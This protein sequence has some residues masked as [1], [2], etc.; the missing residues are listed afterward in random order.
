MQRTLRSSSLVP[1]GLVVDDVV[2]DGDRTSITVRGSKSFAV[3]PACGAIS[4]RVH[5]RYRRRVGDLPISGK[6]VELQVL[7]RRFRCDAVLC[8]R[9]IF[10]ERFDDGALAPWARRTARLDFVVHHLGLALGGRPAASFARRLMLPVSNDTLLRVVRRRPLL[11]RA[12]SASTTGLGGAISGTE[13]SSAT[14]SG[15]DRSLSCP[16]ESR[17][18]RR[19]GSRG[20]RKLPCSRVTAAAVTPLQRPRH[21]RTLPRSP[22]V[23]ISWRT[24]ATPSSMR[25]A[26]RCARCEPQS[27]PPPLIP[28]CSPS[29]SASSMRA[30]YAV[31]TPTRQSSNRLRRA[32]P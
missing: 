25:F 26:N 9:F 5:S 19:P 11:R 29:P 21:F 2:C 27:A 30:I 1:P 31:R 32:S 16:T 4:R 28:T 6:C 23:G 22:T 10:T 18:P 24:P 13:Q 3:C 17:P 15:A 14:S 12:L 20:S 7:A 8:D